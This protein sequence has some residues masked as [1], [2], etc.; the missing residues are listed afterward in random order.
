MQLHPWQNTRAP[1]PGR[2]LGPP[3][4]LHEVVEVL[5]D[6]VPPLE[7]LAAV[8]QQ[9]R[10]GGGMNMR[11]KSWMHNGVTSQATALALSLQCCQSCSTHRVGHIVR[12]DG[13]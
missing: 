10:G 2:L 12:C 5:G 8:R 13:V 7:L 9:L 4:L 3:H 11:F 6:G 1:A